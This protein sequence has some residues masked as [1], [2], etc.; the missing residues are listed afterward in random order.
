MDYPLI[1]V[2]VPVYNVEKYLKRCVDSLLSQTYPNIEIILVN[3][4]ST[5][6][7]WNICR[8]FANSKPNVIALSKPNGGQSSAR[9]LGVGIA[10][11]DYIGFID[12]DDW[13]EP[14]M[15]EYLYEL[16]QTNNAQIAQINYEYAYD[17]HHRTTL[18]NE[19][20]EVVDGSDSILKHYMEQATVTGDYSVCTCLLDS[21]IAKK[22]RFREGKTCEDIDYKFKILAEC[23]RF[24]A[25]NLI[26]YYYFQAGNSTSSGKL[27]SKNFDLYESAELIYRECLI[28]P[29]KRTQFLGKVK[30]S[31]T[32]FSLLSKAAF[33][34]VSNE[35]GDD[36]IKTLVKE[37]RSNLPI[38]LKAPMPFSR[39]AAAI[40]FAIDFK[41]AKRL[42]ALYKKISKGKI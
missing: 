37:H 7:S 30:K 12:S 6:G 14:D 36:I 16:L 2:I 17:S 28:R 15:Y 1:S 5:D 41:F 4:G 29:D 38:L 8:E 23:T 32:A 31:R 13:I 11:G 39:K 35:I 25:S 42:I 22:H 40:A 3:D 26:K 24:V 27:T 9:N 18:R 21:V 34:G 20:V 10:H 19:R 33:Y